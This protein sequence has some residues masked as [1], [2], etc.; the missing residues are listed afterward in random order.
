MGKEVRLDIANSDGTNGV[1][2]REAN[3]FSMSTHRR[4]WDGEPSVGN[5]VSGELEASL[6]LD[7]SLVPRNAK[8]T[9]YIRDGGSWV[10]KGEFFVFSRRED[11]ERGVLKITANDAIYKAEVPFVQPGNI[12]T[13]PKTDIAVMRE[14]ATR[15]GTTIHADS[16]AAI[17]RKYEIPFPGIEIE[18]TGGTDYKSD[19]TTTMREVAGR[20]A[21]MY[22]GNWIIDNSGK[23][24]LVMLSDIP[25]E[26]HYL[27]EEHGDVILIGG[28]RIL[29]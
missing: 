6:W 16:I 10:K 28:V 13:W 8:L 20:I 11:K 24:R 27:V 5:C 2:Y 29:V 26:T 17:N 7:S 9:P 15:T 22:A 12:G 19:G 18:G 1:T 14:I 23:W 3:I 25:P 4:L 21:A